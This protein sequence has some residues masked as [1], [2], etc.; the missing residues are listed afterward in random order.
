MFYFSA[1]GMYT[2]KSMIFIKK[3]MVFCLTQ[4]DL[5]YILLK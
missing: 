5:N 4:L 1:F 2:Y 3:L